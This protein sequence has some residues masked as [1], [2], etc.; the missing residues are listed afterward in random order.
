MQVGQRATEAGPLSKI[1]TDAESVVPREVPVEL[2]L[3][4]VW[5][6]GLE[7]ATFGI[8]RQVEVSDHW[9]LWTNVKME[10]QKGTKSTN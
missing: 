10:P 9:P 4:W 1:L 6:R 5:M 3:D 8:D 7:A 2:K